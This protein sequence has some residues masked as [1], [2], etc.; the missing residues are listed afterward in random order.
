MYWRAI[1]TVAVMELPVQDC[2]EPATVM[3][4]ATHWMT[5]AWILQKF[6]VLQVPMPSFM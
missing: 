6:A 1:Q 4:S 2:Q 3:K 5:A